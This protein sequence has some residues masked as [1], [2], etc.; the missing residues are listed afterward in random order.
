MRKGE[1]GSQKASKTSRAR[2]CSAVQPMVRSVELIL[3]RLL[4]LSN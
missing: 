1:R 3:R 2:F 4:E